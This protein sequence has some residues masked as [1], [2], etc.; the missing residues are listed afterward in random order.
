[1]SSTTYV[2]SFYDIGRDKWPTFSRK[3]DDYFKHFTPF[4]KLLENDES[5]NKLI[6]YMDD[7]HL[8][9]LSDLIVGIDAITVIPINNNWMNSHLP[10][11]CRIEREREIMDSDDYKRLI[12][13]RV[14]FPEHNN[15]R[16]TMINHCKIDFVAHAIGD[17]PDD[18]YFCWVDFGYFQESSR[19]PD[20]LMDLSKLDMNRVNYTLI[21]PLRDIDLDPIYTL[22][23]APEIVGGFWFFGER[24]LLLRYSELYHEVMDTFQHTLNIADDDQAIVLQCISR[25]RELFKLHMLGGWHLALLTFSG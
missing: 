6:V 15:P 2:T 7:R 5:T 11:W 9:K 17:H 21:N 18:D 1:M 19:I 20:K 4:I 23:V 16:Y 10:N 3:V 25:Q 13:G 24:T 8:Q 14:R 12:G 22:K